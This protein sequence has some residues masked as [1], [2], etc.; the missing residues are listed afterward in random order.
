MELDTQDIGVCCVFDGFDH[1]AVQRCRADPD[2]FPEFP[3][4]LMMG[5]V[6]EGFAIFLESPIPD[7]FSV[8]QKQNP[9]HVAATKFSRI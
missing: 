9:V 3:D 4:S 5:A 7:E 8:F 6:N 2:P 1:L